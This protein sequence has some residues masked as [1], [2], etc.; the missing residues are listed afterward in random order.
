MVFNLYLFLKNVWLNS[1][2]FPYKIKGNYTK[3][4]VR[5]QSIRIAVDNLRTLKRART[6]SIKEPET[7]D[8]TDSFGPDSVYFD[9]GANIGQYSF[10]Y[11]AHHSPSPTG[12][13]EVCKTP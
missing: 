9:L 4:N 1:L 13:K 7:L 12:S 5:E 8:W 6:Y 10:P 3:V 11:Q 2:V